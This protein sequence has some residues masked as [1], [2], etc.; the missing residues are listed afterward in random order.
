MAGFEH[1]LVVCVG[2]ICRSPTAE[3][4]LK[5]ALPGKRIESAGLAAVV[6]ADIEP[7]AR[8]VAEA[9]GLSCP[10]HKARQLT[11]EMCREADLILVMESRHRDGVAELCPEARGKIFLLAQGQN[12]AEVADPYRKAAVVF[13]Q[14]Y[15]QLHRACQAWVRRLS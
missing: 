14:T 5:Q 6:G 11:R 8:A 1:V 2:N 4:L 15:E 9:R 7:T 3:F 12:P 10:Q 13:E